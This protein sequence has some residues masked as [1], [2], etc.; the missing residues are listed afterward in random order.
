MLWAILSL[1]AGLGD[2]T[3]FAITKKL[4]GVNKAIII[5]MQVMIA[6]PF[7][8]FFLSI[9]PPDKVGA[10]TYV[11]GAVL[12]VML[13]GNHYLLISAAQIG[14]LSLSMPLLSTTPLFLLFTSYVMLHEFPTMWGI[15]GIVFIVV[16]AY[17][18]N[19]RKE[20]KGFLAPFS[21]LLSSKGS[22]LALL[23]AFVMSI[24]ANLFKIGILS[25]S[26]LFFS[27]LLHVYMATLMT[28]LVFVKYRRKINEIRKNAKLLTLLGLSTAFMS[29]TAAYANLLA[30]VPY[31]VS[32]KR[33]SAFFSILYGKF[34]FG[35]DHLMHAITGTAIMLVGGALIILL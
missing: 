16:G 30:I 10:S 26:P 14:S 18:I 29:V 22:Q 3:I 2:A 8:L 5:W 7:L 1:A 23:A 20:R 11:V 6:A 24:M 34:L 31:V 9:Y 32:L 25:S 28:L 27:T 15:A 33:S 13:I 21:L 12:G 17:V 4:K 35:E 19:I